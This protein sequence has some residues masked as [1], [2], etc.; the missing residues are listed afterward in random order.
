MPTATESMRR[1]RHALGFAL[2]LGLAPISAAWAQ[3]VF[4][5]E[6]EWAALVRVLLPSAQLH[7]ATHAQQDPHHIEARPAL[8][9]QMRA[10]DLAVCTGA[11][12]EDGW[13]PLLQQKSGN[14]KV[15]NRQPGMFFAAQGQTLIGAGASGVNPFAGDVHPEGNPH[16]HANPQR[17][18]LVARQLSQRMTQLWPDQAPAIEQ[19][20]NAFEPRWQNLIDQWQARVRHLR[21]Q[22]VAAQHTHFAYWWEWLQIRQVADLEP[23]P[24]LSPT[25]AHLQQIAQ[26]LRAARPPVLGLAIASHQDPRASRWMAQQVPR[27]A[28]WTWPATVTQHNEDGLRT[29]FEGM[30]ADLTRSAP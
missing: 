3:V 16:L 29:W 23:K 12:L 30:I 11:G 13:L 24:G 26:Q 20:L 28:V 10:A 4:A 17:L 2:A 25:P 5:C 7:V 21:G 18:L 27:L 14:P 6:P 9:A 22:N 19:R 15:Q 8:I 1:L